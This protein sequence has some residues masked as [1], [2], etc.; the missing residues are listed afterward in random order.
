MG[1]LHTDEERGRP[2]TDRGGAGGHHRTTVHEQ[3]AV[4]RHR[5]PGT[6]AIDD[7][8]QY[9]HG[10][11]WT[12]EPPELADG[13]I[14]WL[15]TDEWFAY[16]LRVTEPIDGLSLRVASA[17]GFGGG[18]LGIVVDDAPVTRVQF[19]ATGG[20]YDW[21]RVDVA[22]SLEPGS[23]TLRLVVFDGGWKLSQFELV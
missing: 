11:R 14:D 16:D 17:A 6:V 13:E 18:D 9:F 19:D 22:L 1:G 8:H 5:I 20:W 23:H 2:D 10:G 12:E 4:D 7:Y 15:A 21:D 3:P